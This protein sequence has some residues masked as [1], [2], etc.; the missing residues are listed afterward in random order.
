[1]S[2]IIEGFIEI[3]K[4]EID[5]DYKNKVI[6]HSQY[7]NLTSEVYKISQRSKRIT[8]ENDVERIIDS[9]NTFREIYM[10]MR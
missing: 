4:E 8:S 5:R 6:T 2:G 9:L 10:I 1:M 7:V 3:F